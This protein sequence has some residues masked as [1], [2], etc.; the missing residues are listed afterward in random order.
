MQIEIDFL[1]NHP[2]L[3]Q[4][5]ASWF[6]HEWGRNNPALSPQI[7]ESAVKERLHRHSL[8]LCL[9]A[10][11]QQQPIATT[12][13]KIK[14]MD[15]HPHFDH[16]LGNVFVLPDFRRQGVASIIIKRTITDAKRIGI[17]DLYLYTRGQ[18]SLYE[19]LGWQSIE[20][21][22]YRG[23]PASIMHQAII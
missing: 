14:E 19:I 5:L 21:T 12:A 23:R 20:Q 11:H 13:L 2:D 1:A 4:T 9:I 15:T 17:S 3:T 16:W 8:P 18:E 7:M 6:Y 10:F 22:I